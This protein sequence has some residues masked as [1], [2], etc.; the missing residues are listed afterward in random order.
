MKQK[1][2][3]VHPR[4]KIDNSAHA[5]I[6]GSECDKSRQYQTWNYERKVVD[7]NDVT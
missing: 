6:E 1:L 7:K 5:G 3:M 4:L 2:S